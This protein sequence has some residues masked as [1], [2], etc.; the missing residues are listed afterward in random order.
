M[1]LLILNID[2]ALIAPLP[3]SK[4]G[5]QRTA[6]MTNLG[7][8]VQERTK[9]DAKGK[10]NSASDDCVMIPG[11]PLNPKSYHSADNGFDQRALLAH[12]CRAAT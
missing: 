7:C 1:P 9:M 4:F 12:F 5:C 3:L 11:K 8:L 10:A 6:V 2:A